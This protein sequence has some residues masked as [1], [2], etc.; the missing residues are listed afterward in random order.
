MDSRIVHNYFFWIDLPNF[1][2]VVIFYYYIIFFLIPFTSN[3]QWIYL[4]YSFVFIV[5]VVFLISYQ[6]TN[7]IFF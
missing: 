6:F 1:L 2:V 4:E 3:I 5:I 7:L